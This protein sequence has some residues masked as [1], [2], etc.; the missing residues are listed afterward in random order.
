[1]RGLQGKVG[2]VA[3]GGGGIGAATA[4]RLAEEGAHVAIGG[5]RA[6][7]VEETAANIRAAGGQAVGMAFD[8]TTPEGVGALVARAISEY[9][10]LDFY[11]SNLAGGL[12]GDNTALDCPL[13]IFDYSIAI[14]ARAHLIATQAALPELL[15]RE[16]GGCIIFTSSAAAISGS[17]VTP[18][19]AMAKNGTHALARHIAQRWGKQGIRANVVCPG[20][21]LTDSALTN[22]SE[23]MRTAVEKTV[24]HRRLGKAE[25]IAATVAFL[26]SDDGEWV[27]GQV[28]HVNGGMNMRD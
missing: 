9:G 16:N 23:N 13:N 17:P 4:Q 18:A 1:M 8:G 28:W 5:T 22:L 21:V 15:K 20:L 26:V 14:N 10:H 6:A 27:N 11:H 25:D 24:P 19:Y 2:I 3:G 7:V 12:E